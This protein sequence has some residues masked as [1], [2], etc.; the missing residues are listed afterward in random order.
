MPKKPTTKKVVAKAPKPKYTLTV[1]MNDEVFS[2]S[3]N[4]VV[5]AL[6]ELSPSHI[7]TRVIIRVENA[8]S[9]IERIMM[10]RQ[11][12]LLFRNQITMQTFV[13]NV[14]LGLKNE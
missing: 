6:T 2:C 7:K 14:L 3:T 10:V 1:R 11:A 12:K 13:R 4:D 9:A 8:F 5:A